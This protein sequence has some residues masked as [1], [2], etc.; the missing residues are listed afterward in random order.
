MFSL[1][2]IKM[3]VT[4]FD[5]TLAG[6]KAIVSPRNIKALEGLKE[7]GIIRVIATGRSLFSLAQVIDKDFPIDFVVF[8]TGVGVMNHTLNEIYY[9]YSFNNHEVDEVYAWLKNQHYNFMIHL[10]VPDNHIFYANH[11][12]ELHSDFIRRI[13]HYDKLKVNLHENIP[14]EAAQFVVICENNSTHYEKIKQQFPQYKV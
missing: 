13:E 1:Q 6:D 7:T 10:P 5:G 11:S 9:S 4:D 8:S 3:F 14:N 2:N 12:K